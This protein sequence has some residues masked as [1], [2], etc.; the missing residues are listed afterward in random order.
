MIFGGVGNHRNMF[1]H[2][3]ISAA[4][5]ETMIYSLVDASKTIYKHL[6]ED[7]DVF[8]DNLNSYENQMH[9]LLVL[10]QELCIIY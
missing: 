7:H 5:L 4:V 1:F 3:V 10:A 6:P 2:S 8:W 9:S